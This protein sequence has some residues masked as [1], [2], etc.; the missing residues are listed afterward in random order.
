LQ[1]IPDQASFAV[2]DI[3]TLTG[4]TRIVNT[5][6]GLVINQMETRIERLP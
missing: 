5:K 1:Y 2:S 4:D 6:S 3:S